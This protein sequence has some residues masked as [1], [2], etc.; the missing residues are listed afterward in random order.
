MSAVGWQK[1]RRVLN[2]R[3]LLHYVNVA[4]GKAYASM[5]AAVT[6]TFNIRL[7]FTVL[8]LIALSNF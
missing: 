7:R 3:I 8:P 6:G 1:I 2:I 4:L 5:K